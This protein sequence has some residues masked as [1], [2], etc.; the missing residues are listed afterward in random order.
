[1]G[2]ARLSALLAV[3]RTNAVF[4]TAGVSAVVRTHSA[5]VRTREVH[6][7]RVSLRDSVLQKQGSLFSVIVF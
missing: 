3:V 1:M 6:A 7:A 5:V 4:R 2:L